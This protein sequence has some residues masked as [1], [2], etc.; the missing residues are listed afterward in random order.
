MDLWYRYVCAGVCAYVHASYI[1][2][3]EQHLVYVRM[4]RT[5]VVWNFDLS[6]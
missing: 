2:G 6:P 4:L 3:P 1:G 5:N